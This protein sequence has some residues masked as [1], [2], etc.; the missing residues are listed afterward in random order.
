[1]SFELSLGWGGCLSIIF[2]V[3]IL[4]ALIFGVTIKGIHYGI[5]C[6]CNDGVVLNVGD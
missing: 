6:N 3:I 1:M 5:D 4:F 2:T